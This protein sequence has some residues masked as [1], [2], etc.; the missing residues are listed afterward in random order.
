MKKNLYF[1]LGIPGSGKSTYLSGKEPIVSTDEIRK[2]LFGDVNFWSREQEVFGVAQ[3]RIIN[4]FSSYQ[5]VYLDAT[6]VESKHRDPFL[7]E[8]K[9]E[10]GDVKFTAIL[11]EAD[12]ELSR[13]RIKQDL[14]DGFDRASNA[15]KNLYGFNYWYQ[16]TLDLIEK[17]QVSFAVVKATD[18]G[19]NEI[20]TCQACGIKYTID[21][22]IPDELWERIKPKDKEVGAGLLC[23]SCIMK[24]LE[25]ILG[26]SAYNL[27]KI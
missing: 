21:I 23:G 14:S 3:N 24:R 22:I 19:C 4:Y 15:L 1:T 6:M 5:T 13:Q 7:A 25:N 27:I 17:N 10:V 8:I 18:W 12:V 26:Y 9:E 20:C 2:Q 11:F 16:E